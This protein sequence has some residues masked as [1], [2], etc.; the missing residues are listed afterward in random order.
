MI[1]NSK[2][3][4]KQMKAPNPNKWIKKFQLKQI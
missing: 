1:S 2:K 3:I 4:E